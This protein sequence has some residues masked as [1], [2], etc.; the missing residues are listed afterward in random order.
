[1]VDNPRCKSVDFKFVKNVHHTVCG[2]PWACHGKH[3]Q[4]NCRAM[5][6]AWTAARGALEKDL[7]RAIPTM[8]CTRHGKA[9]YNSI[10]FPGEWESESDTVL[11]L[12]TAVL[13]QTAT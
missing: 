2:K 8:Q 5:H 10:N 1:M 4:A 12:Y 13:L 9:G 7:G 11:G 3:H 6:A